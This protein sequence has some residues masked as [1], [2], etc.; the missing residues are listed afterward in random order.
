MQKK[1][2]ETLKDNPLSVDEIA[3]TLN[4][5]DS[6]EFIKLNKE[7]NKLIY[8]KKA[9]EEKGIIY[10]ADCF[11]QGAVDIY[12]G[13]AYVGD[14]EVN[15]S[16]NI[17]LFSGDIILYKENKTSVT[18]IKVIQRALAYILG[19]MVFR[20]GKLYFFSDDYRLK[21]FK[22]VNQ[23]EF[24]KEL[25]PDYKVRA[26]ISSY[27]KKELKIDK[28]IGKADNEETIIET[29]LLEN[30][31]PNPFS[32]K[33]LKECEEIDET[34]SL[35]NRK[36]LREYPFVT[37]DGDDA[38]DFDDA[39]CVE[40][41]EDGYM[42]HV[43]I[44]D[45]TN[46]VK[47]D[48]TLDKE[49]YNRGTSIYYPGKVIPM[50]PFKL[51]DNLCS[52]MENKERYTLTCSMHIDYS[53]KL[54][55][56][57]IYPSVIKSKHRLTYNK[58][59]KMFEH[60]VNLIKEYEDVKDMLFSAYRLSRILDK[61]RKEKGGIEFKTIEPIIIE[62]NGKVVDIKPRVQ[63]KAEEM[64]EVFMIEA[65]KTVASH[66]YYLNMPMIYR[67]HDYPK[68]DKISDFVDTIATLGY[69]F[70]GNKFKIEA[71]A[72]Q[73]CL[74]YFEGTSEFAL[75][76]DMLLRSMAKALYSGNCNGHY[77]LGLEHYCHFTSPIRRY[78]DLIVHRCLK[79]YVFNYSEDSD[80]YKLKIESIANK[81][82]EREKCAT[83]IEREIV[84]LKMCE[85]M[86]DKIK[87]KFTGVITSVTSFGFFVRLENSVE[88]L[89][90]VKNLD[91]YYEFE[92]NVLTNGFKE[93]KIGQSVK[94]KLINVDIEQRNIDFI[95]L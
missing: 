2:I 81:A 17:L 4:I 71:S 15:N 27:E 33:V 39:I 93:Y 10:L 22:V 25:K 49:A 31:A 43:A 6:K 36:D 38:K 28:V 13:K 5:K 66:M 52:L 74:S 23:K 77:G 57:D 35:E 14:L 1:L 30:K 50:L 3:T 48:S 90:H 18:L 72:L 26:Y 94:V 92:N 65:N 7:V 83:M 82:N 58:V 89:V 8:E 61:L 91:D 42:L 53:G 63:G 29:I 51:S 56:Y 86:K 84:D 75:V 85:F 55:D 37:I 64:I 45:V 60:D 88:G 76:N 54:L 80:A 78:P 87:E 16:N 62:E 79:K 21:D 20:K 68:V 34:I 40:E 47:E 46:Y 69:T 67:N 24:N 41:K 59:N 32:N 9:Y 70:K 12:K 19:T 95:V 44:A 73:K 11:K